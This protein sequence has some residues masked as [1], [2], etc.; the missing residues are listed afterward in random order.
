MTPEEAFLYQARA[1]ANLGSPFMRQLLTA[2][3]PRIAA[4]GPVYDR[5]NSWDDDITPSGASVPLRVAGGLHWLVLSGD[6]PELAAVYPPAEVKDAALIADVEAAFSAH[7]RFFDAWLDNPPQTNEVRRAA[8]LVAAANWLMDHYPLPLRVSE[9]GASA[10]LNLGFDQIAVE[11]D[12]GR[13]GPYD[14][15]LTLRPDW[16]GPFPSRQNIN[17]TDRRGADLRPIDISDADHCLRLMSFLWPDQPERLEATKAAMSLARDLG[18]FVDAGDA[19]DW[20]EARLVTP[21]P[22]TLHLIYHTIAWQYFPSAT[23]ARCPTIP[24]RTWSRSAN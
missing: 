8:V 16:T 21:E 19:A 12:T 23:A 13:I 15:R 4:G 17:V 18:T 14:A 20:I 9:L 10:G 1:C 3:A 6:A 11:T 2:L 7:A 22:G 24:A 5:I